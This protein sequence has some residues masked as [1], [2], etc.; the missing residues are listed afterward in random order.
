MQTFKLLAT[1]S[2]TVSSSC[3]K[4]WLLA[5]LKSSTMITLKP[6]A[7]RIGSE[8]GTAELFDVAF[9]DVDIIDRR[10][11]PGSICWKDQAV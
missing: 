1:S 9:V 6:R 10:R 2:T 7:T 11:L 3:S 8:S 4:T 5:L